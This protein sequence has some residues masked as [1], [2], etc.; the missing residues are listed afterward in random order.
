MTLHN[1]AHS[2]RLASA[3][4]LALLLL[5]APARAQ[6]DAI[7]LAW[8]PSPEPIVSGYFLY[9]VRAADGVT[10][11]FDAGTRTQFTY[12]GV[13][14]STGYTFSVAAYT[15]EGVTGS[16]S[17]T[18]FYMA[19]SESSQNA[20]KPGA[21]DAPPATTVRPPRSPMATAEPA[22]ARIE[23]GVITAIAALPDGRIALVEEGRRV[24]FVSADGRVS[25][26]PALV[27]DASSTILSLAVDP[28][29][30][31]SRAMFLGMRDSAEQGTRS[32][33]LVRYR[34][35]GGTLG[36][37][38][39]IVEGL[40]AAED[41]SM[42]VTID[43]NGRLYVAVPATSDARSRFASTVLR[44][45]ADGSAA[46]ENLGAS[47]EF[48]R[49]FA[50]PTALTWSEE[51]GTVWLSGSDSGARG[52]TRRIVVGADGPGPVVIDPEDGALL[53]LT[54]ERGRV[55]ASRLTLPA[56]QVATHVTVARDGSIVA[57][58]SDASGAQ[59]LVRFDR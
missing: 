23:A 29:F 46:A 35:V 2:F 11:Q 17:Q 12:T 27:V 20:P 13:R 38:A 4:A 10:Q 54:D 16:R 5:S 59:T 45:E 58:V 32:A 47:P 53:R 43:A 37:P 55:S 50:R 33:R 39:V 14:P 48:T 36:Q 44:F 25:A 51:T 9:V 18:V 22:P 6:S 8:D 52:E 15:A 31:E 1:A 7:T 41:A 21:S 57:I 49:G 42:P 30:A 34:E 3:L 19:G 40:P 28:A 24:R 26:D 56:G